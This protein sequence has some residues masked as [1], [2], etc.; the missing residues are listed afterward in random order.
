M[1]EWLIAALGGD[2]ESAQEILD[3]GLLAEHYRSLLPDELKDAQPAQLD[4]LAVLDGAFG[5]SIKR[6]RERRGRVRL[7]QDDRDL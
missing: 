6:A 4:Q 2:V 5:Q 1:K 3:A 7:P